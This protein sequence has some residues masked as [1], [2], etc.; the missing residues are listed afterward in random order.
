[1]T[2]ENYKGTKQKTDGSPQ[3]SKRQQTNMKVTGASRHVYSK[4]HTKNKQEESREPWK[5]LGN[6]GGVG[7]PQQ[8]L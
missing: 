3:S 6:G 1:M 2:K 7:M 4:T 8:M 5:Q